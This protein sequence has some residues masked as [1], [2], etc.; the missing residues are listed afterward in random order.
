MSTKYVPDPKALVRAA[1]QK[2]GIHVSRHRD[3][4]NT[5]VYRSLHSDEVLSRRPFYNVGAGSFS[6]PYWTNID[7]VSDWYGGVQQNVIHHDLMSEG[8]LPIDDEAAKIIYTSHTVEHIKD[9]AVLALFKEAYRTLEKGGVFRITTGPDA[10]TDFRALMR[11]DSNWFYWDE[12]YAKPGS[13]EQIYT[14]P[15]TS[16]SLAERWLHHVAS[17]LTRIDKSPSAIKF[18]EAE[19]LRAIEERGFP[20]VLDYFCGLV[21]FDPTRPGNHISWWTHQKI[22]DFLRVAGF[23]QMYRSGWNQ[24]ASPLLRNSNLFDSTHPQMSIYV[25]AIK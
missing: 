16:V 11:K 12:A 15:A 13:Y 10:E 21:S 18:T 20:G 23:G 8:P 5:S 25:E 9:S 24:S 7:Y 22:L 3:P 6:H 19:I 17:P 2:L 14:A 4:F 1:L